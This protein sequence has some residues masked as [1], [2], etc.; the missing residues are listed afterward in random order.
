MEVG[1]TIKAKAKASQHLT[2][3]QKTVA[4]DRQMNDNDTK[5][6]KMKSLRPGKEQCSSIDCCNGALQKTY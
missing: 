6:K 4:S 2:E 3:K 5:D 1:C